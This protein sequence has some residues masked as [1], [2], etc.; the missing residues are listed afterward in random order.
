MNEQTEL[1]GFGVKPPAAMLTRPPPCARETAGGEHR[2][3]LSRGT[4]AADTDGGLILG[5]VMLNPSTADHRFDDPTIRRIR[6]F[7]ASYGAGTALVGNLFT[8]RATNPAHLMMRR[9]AHLILPHHDPTEPSPLN[10]DQADDALRWIL[11]ISGAVVV[12]WGQGT[13]VPAQLQPA[14]QQREMEVLDLIRK[15]RR[16]CFCLGLTSEG[17]PRHPLYMPADTRLRVFP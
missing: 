11:E 7:T 9:P 3:W 1:A 5:W 14:F 16:N 17:R 13:G 10:A 15:S 12:A 8:K 6:G 2:M 4:G